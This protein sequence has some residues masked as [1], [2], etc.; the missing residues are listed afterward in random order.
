MKPVLIATLGYPGSGKT[1][2]S[3]R[4]AKE[5]KLFHLNADSLR[6][7]LIAKPLFTPEE[8]RR[9][10]NF[11]DTTAKQLLRLEVSTIY[12]ANFNKCIFRNSLADLA[13]THNARY[14][15]VW[16]RT[17]AEKAL[18]R[19]TGRTA[20]TDYKYRPLTN[21]TFHKL[22]EEIE[23]PTPDEPLIEISGEIPFEEQLLEFKKGL[24]RLFDRP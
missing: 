24:T 18:S 8:H 14:V 6:F 10:F 13:H 3:E 12:D 7:S 15:L 1:H 2:F 4:L 20:S 21:E 22:R 11:M 16:I 9:V 19:A 17:D 5:E 23:S